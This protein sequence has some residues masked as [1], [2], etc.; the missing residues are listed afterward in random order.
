MDWNRTKLHF[1]VSDEHT[2]IMQLEVDLLFCV[3]ALVGPEPGLE[4]LCMH[5]E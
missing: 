2:Q 3:Y 5:Q 1:S 4:V